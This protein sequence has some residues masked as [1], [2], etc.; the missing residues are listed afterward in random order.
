M[1][2]RLS[3]N[4]FLTIVFI[5]I[6]MV[7]FG[8]FVACDVEGN[9]TYSLEADG[10][11]NVLVYQ[12][13][14]NFDRYFS[15]SYIKKT[16]ESGEEFFIPLTADMLVGEIDTHSVGTKS[17]K[18]EYKEQ[19]FNFE[20]VVKY[21]VDFISDGKVF[22]TQLVLN[23]NELNLNITPSVLPCI[24]SAL[25]PNS[26]STFSIR[27]NNSSCPFTHIAMPCLGS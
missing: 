6:T 27:S 5:G 10:I 13:E 20:Y 8:L 17:I 21:K 16:T 9:D 11:E 2:Q 12:S 1:G 14:F 15:D 3:F 7:F 22:D 4:K 26:N 25:S 19:E 18:L 24:N 23:K